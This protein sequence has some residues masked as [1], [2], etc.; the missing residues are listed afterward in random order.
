MMPPNHTDQ[1]PSPGMERRIKNVSSSKL[2]ELTPGCRIWMSN[3]GAAGRMARRGGLPLPT[4]LQNRACDVNRTRLLNTWV[5]V[6]DTLLGMER[7]MPL[8]MTMPMER[9]LIAK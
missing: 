4:R 1:S 3:T 2:L 5:P 9:L 6:M 8:V 7:R